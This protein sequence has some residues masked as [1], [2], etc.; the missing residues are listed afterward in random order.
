MNTFSTK[1]SD[2]KREWH[3]IDA[4]G[5]VLGGVAT[6]AARLLMGKHKAIFCRHLDTGDHVVIINA[7]KVRATGNKLKQKLYYRHSRYPGGLKAVTLG[8]LLQTNPERAIEHAVKGMLP[9]NRLEAKMMRRLRV[10]SEEQH[11]HMGQVAEVPHA[12]VRVAKEE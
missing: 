4:S 5:Q 7:G 9:H 10:Y 2:I 1:V 11:P 6:E 3:V 12:A 8:D